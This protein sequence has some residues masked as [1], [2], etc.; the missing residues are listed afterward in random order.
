MKAINLKI[1]L[2]LL[3]APLALMAGEHKGKYKKEKKINKSFNVASDAALN[4]QNKYGNI[5]VTTWDKNQTT[6]DVTIKVSGNNEKKV[7]K[8]IN[9]IDVDFYN[10]PESVTART[11]IDKLM[12]GTIS[13]DINYTIKIPKN[14]SI[15]LDN[16]YG[17]IQLS[18]INGK[19]RI[20][21]K[22]GDLDIEELRHTTNNID[23][24]YCD[25]STIGFIKSGTVNV[26]YSELKIGKMENAEVNS[27]Y[28]DV[29]IGMAEDL[30]YRSDYGD[31]KIGSTS[32]ING[33]STYSSLKV[34]RV[35][36]AFDVEVQYGDIKAGLE[37]TIKSVAVN[38]M[39]SD[40]V[41]NHARGTNFDFE[42]ATQY[43]DVSGIKG[44]TI[45]S[46]EEKD[47]RNRYKGYHGSSGN[48]RIYIKN[49]YGDIKLIEK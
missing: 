20:R 17:G 5:Y 46:K 39:Y 35:K 40:V 19:S 18:K 26:Q 28:T 7:E 38:S 23:I 42:F 45:L 41:L 47:F 21:C 44:F 25:N 22:Y 36:K 30:R 6:I 24:Q 16:M 43:G 2:L 32:S 4:V 49:S 14:G 13:I 27:Q 34:E 8:T 11:K 10:S 29:S 33:T 48:A 12:N 15:D 1:V 37:K 3:V 9:G 31:V